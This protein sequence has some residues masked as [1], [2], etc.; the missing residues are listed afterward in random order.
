VGELLVSVDR[1]EPALYRIAV[2]AAQAPEQELLA[3]VV[4]RARPVMRLGSEP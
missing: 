4:F 1:P 3:T 2:A